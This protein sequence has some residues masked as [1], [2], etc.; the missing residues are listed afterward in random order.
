MILMSFCNARSGKVAVTLAN[1]EWLAEEQ[2]DKHRKRPIEEAEL[3]TMT[4]LKVG[5]TKKADVPLLQ[6]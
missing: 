2:T 5:S 1:D 3:L 4:I 6:L